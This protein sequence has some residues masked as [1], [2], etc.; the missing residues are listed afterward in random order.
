MASQP[1]KASAVEVIRW[2]YLA[3][4]LRR[5]GQEEAAELWY[6]K[7]SQWLRDS[8][9]EPVEMTAGHESENPV[10]QPADVGRQ[11]Q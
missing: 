8:V 10:H 6:A 7:A 11:V 2:V 1:N 4:E 9:Y 3:R 5:R